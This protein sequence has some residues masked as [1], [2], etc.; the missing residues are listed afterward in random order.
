MSRKSL[1]LAVALTLVAGLARGAD[2]PRFRGPNGDGMFAES[3]LLKVWPEGGPKMLW[4]VDGLGES[5]ASMSVAGGRIYTT[6]MAAEE[7]AWALLWIMA[8][9]KIPIFP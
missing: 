9:G 2:S 1:L 4:A 6:G 3:G 8:L 7:S 5:Y